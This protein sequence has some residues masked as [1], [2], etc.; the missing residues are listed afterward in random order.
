MTHEI[1]NWWR[2]RPPKY[3][4][5]KEHLECYE[6]KQ[7]V[8]L[9]IKYLSWNDFSPLNDFFSSGSAL[10]LLA[11][12]VNSQF[13]PSTSAVPIDCQK[14]NAVCLEEIMK[15]LTQLRFEVK[16]L[17]ENRTLIYEES[18]SRSLL[19]KTDTLSDDIST[20]IPNPLFESMPKTSSI[21]ILSITARNCAELYKSGRRISGVYTIDPDGSGAF[22][23]YCDQTTANG[24]WTVI[25][26][27]MDGSV[28]F[29][30][31]WNEYK[32]GFGNLVGE[33]WLGLDKINRLTRN[34]TKNKLRVD[35]GVTTGKT[36]HP[37]Y[38]WFGI[39]NETAKYR[40]YI[41]NITTTQ[42]LEQRVVKDKSSKHVENFVI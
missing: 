41:G 9:I 39:G 5:S 3:G 8:A 29:N 10:L 26:K 20:F 17:T 23:V 15:E 14:N 19:S 42:Q 22:N 28:D 4:S 34:K 35:L 33:F 31:T 40:L 18:K 16:I 36:V 6:E 2:R 27:R 38:D 11:L 25:Q 32:H 7:C 1:E 21:F 13:I 37:E 24:G 12:F 30:R